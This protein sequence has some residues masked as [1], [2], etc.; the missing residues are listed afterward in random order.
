MIITE[1]AMRKDVVQ[2]LILHWH[3]YS[4][5]STLDMEDPS[6]QNISEKFENWE[7][8]RST[9]KEFI[10]TFD[11]I[12]DLAVDHP[13]DT[14]FI[15]AR[16]G[17]EILSV[18][19]T[20]FLPFF[21]TDFGFC[22]I[23]KPQVT[24]D[25]RLSGLSWERK[26]LYGPEYPEISY[27]HSWIIQPGAKVGKTNG[28]TMMLDAETFDYM[29]QIKPS[30]GFKMSVQHHL[31]QPLMS[32]NEIDISPGFESQVAVNPTLYTTTPEAIYRFTP[33]ERG[34]YSQKEILMNHLPDGMYRYDIGNCF[35]EAAY[36]KILEECK[37]TPYFHWG[38]VPLD[39]ITSTRPF[40]K[41]ETLLCM[42]EILGKIGEYKEIKYGSKTFPCLAACEDQTNEV[43]I[44]QSTLPNRETLIQR[45]E[46]CLLVYR[47]E[48]SCK[49]FKREGLDE[50]YPGMC[51]R[52]QV[53]ILE[54]LCSEEDK[55]GYIHRANHTGI[56]RANHT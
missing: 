13:G 27:T 8:F 50:Y 4:D 48:K 35:F 29:Y 30:E 36:S 5:T 15:S 53:G 6:N 46:F 49:G 56:L 11:Y 52:I 26:L 22:S 42:N 41:A 51:S 12:R 1:L 17:S 40:C 34:C 3:L 25:P 16:F 39:T 28:F 54:G 14:P 7:K 21:G 9:F 31:D 44:S 47:L 24:F 32:V 18:N 19:T 20:S 45:P 43:S 55:T 23:I 37:C 2:K 38:P 33:E 10:K